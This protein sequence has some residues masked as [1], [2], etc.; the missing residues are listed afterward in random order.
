MVKISL[1]NRNHCTPKRLNAGI[2]AVHAWLTE[3]E[4]RADRVHGRALNCRAGITTNR[5]TAELD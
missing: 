3:I 2:V 5:V 1:F 4:M